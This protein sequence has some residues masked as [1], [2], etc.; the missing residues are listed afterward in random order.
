M[1]ASPCACTPGVFLSSPACSSKNNHVFWRAASV[2][3]VLMFQSGSPTVIFQSIMASVLQLAAKR[4]I[5]TYI[6]ICNEIYIHPR[7]GLYLYQSMHCA[8]TTTTIFTFFHLNHTPLSL[9]HLGMAWGACGNLQ[10][11]RK[12]KGASFSGTTR[13]N[14]AFM[15]HRW[16]A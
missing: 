14:T 7:P 4:M 12:G 5:H 16:K 6:Y 1:A 9:E 11:D 8:N 10:N 3:G 13:S 2:E 15:M